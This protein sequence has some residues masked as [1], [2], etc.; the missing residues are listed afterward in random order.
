MNQ[1]SILTFGCWLTAMVSTSG[2][3][4]FSEIL[5]YPP[6]SLCWYQRIAL[7]PLCAIFAVGLF[8]D[9][10]VNFSMPLV[11][12][13]WMV[14]LYHNLLY[15]RIIEPSFTLCRDAVSCTSEQFN[16]FGITIPILSFL[17]FSL[18]FSGLLIISRIQNEKN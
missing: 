17:A 9:G 2:S 12:F 18:I 3:L 15:Y 5:Q 10:V 8:R 6:C 13:G 16:W 7:F 11:I 4:F 14:S 1:A